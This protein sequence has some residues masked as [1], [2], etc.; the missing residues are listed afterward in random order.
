MEK[1]DIFEK[2]YRQYCEQLSV[3]DSESVKDVLG[4]EHHD[5]GMSVPFFDGT[6]FVSENGIVNTSGVRADYMV[7]VILAKYILLC[8]DKLHYDPDWASIKDFKKNSQF[9]NVNYFSSD[10]EKKIEKQFAGNPEVLKKACSAIGGFQAEMN[11]SYD[12]SFQFDALPRISLLLLFND[13]DDEF[14]AK[15]N[16]LFQK[17]AEFYLDPESLVMMG[18]VLTNNLIKQI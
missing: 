9:T 12:V 1:S 15:C 5:D 17:H 6:Y 8:P 18:T 14:P 3:V 2:N 11:I 16:V 4:I 10:T 13:G 7:S